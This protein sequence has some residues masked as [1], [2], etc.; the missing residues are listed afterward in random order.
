MERADKVLGIASIGPAQF[1]TPMTTTIE[2]DFGAVWRIAHNNNR[3]V[4][5]IADDIIA[6]IGYFGIM[7]E[8]NPAAVEDT[9]N[10]QL[11]DLIT[12]E[13]L[14]AHQPAFNIDPSC[15]ITFHAGMVG[16]RCSERYCRCVFLALMLSK[17]IEL[18]I[19]KRMKWAIYI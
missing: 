1:G 16:Q 8:I 11:V 18:P 19:A 3:R 12:D 13:G 7:A 5:Q 15:S 17:P 9:L 2:Q 4:A 6:N 10:L 14:A